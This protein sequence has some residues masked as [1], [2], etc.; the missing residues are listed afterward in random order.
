MIQWP[1]IIKLEGDDELMY[2]GSK[3]HLQDECEGLIFSD[4]DVLIDSVGQGFTI[5]EVGNKGIE[6]EKNNQSLSVSEV[7]SL[8]QAHEFSKAE[9][10]L[11]KI[12]FLSISE[13]IQSLTFTD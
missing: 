7:T 9:M 10:C 5:R 11:T 12:H 13:A 8:I 4:L 6:T 1:C 2:V 3:K